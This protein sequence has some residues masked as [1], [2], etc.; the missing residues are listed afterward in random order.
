[1]HNQRIGSFHRQ[2]RQQHGHRPI[3][4]MT[5]HNVSTIFNDA[6]RVISV[7]ICCGHPFMRYW[8]PSR[9]KAPGTCSMP[10]PEN[11]RLHRINSFRS[12][13]FRNHGMARIFAPITELLTAWICTNT[14]Y[15]RL[16]TDSKLINIP[17]CKSSRNILPVVEYAILIRYY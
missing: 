3:P 16:N 9:G 14:V 1:M 11:E 12:R 8:Q 17:N 5:V 6:S 15:R 4:R 7:P 13:I 10:H 2:K